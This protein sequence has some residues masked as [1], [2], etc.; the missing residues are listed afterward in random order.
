MTAARIAHNVVA[1]PGLLPLLE[2]HIDLSGIVSRAQWESTYEPP[3]KGYI[4]PPPEPDCEGECPTCGDFRSRRCTL[5]EERWASEWELLRAGYPELVSLEG[6]LA[7]LM[8]VHP[9]WA[10]ALYWVHVQ[11]WDGWELDRRKRWA[12]AGIEWLAEQFP[13]WL[14]VYVP[15][16]MPAEQPLSV[17]A[18]ELRAD[19]LSCRQIARRLGVGKSSVHRALADRHGRIPS[20]GS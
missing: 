2:A 15:K 12:E 8:V 6:L 13:G 5:R 10:S 4:P 9:G 17:A 20:T 19:G 18:A 14:P 16:G 3:P 7:D 11:P 1:L